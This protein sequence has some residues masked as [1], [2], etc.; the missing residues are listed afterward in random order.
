MKPR[1]W[2]SITL[3]IFILTAG[4]AISSCGRLF[5]P[6]PTITPLISSF[7]PSSSMNEIDCPFNVPNQAEYEVSCGQVEVPEDYAEIGGDQI[8][9]FIAILHATGENP[10]R[11]PIVLLPQSAGMSMV[12][13]IAYVGFQLGELLVER[14]L[15]YMEYRGLGNSGPRLDCPE[16]NEAYFQTWLEVLSP[17]QEAAIYEEGLQTCRDRL[18]NLEIDPASYTADEIAADLNAMRLS[19]GYEQF[20]LLAG[21]YGAEV[22]LTMLRDFPQSV[23]GVAVFEVG[24]PREYLRAEM[25]AISLQ[26]SLDLLFNSCQADEDC[27]LAYP[28]LEATL[29]GLVDQYNRQP[30]DVDLFVPGQTGLTPVKVTGSDFLLLIQSMLM[31]NQSI[32]NIPKLV[33]ELGQGQAIRMSDELQSYRMNLPDELVLGVEVSAACEGSHASYLQNT[34]DSQDVQAVIMEAVQSEARVFELVCPLWTGKQPGVPA[35]Q[36]LR[37]EVPL[38]I[39]QGEFTPHL[40]PNVVAGLVREM[41]NVQHIVIPNLSNDIFGGESC[42]GLLMFQWLDDPLADLDTSCVDST[43][44]ID[45]YMP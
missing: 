4:L 9:L 29:Y 17:D 5:A 44:P 28:N 14:D 11:D 15:V 36:P 25:T 43:E 22:A 34:P 7:N 24:I 30:V 31:T 6:E 32:S 39:L 45:F 37:S 38:L 13:V 2:R 20:N 26:G 12:D 35:G 18:L 42:A 27:R 3:L 19:L 23:R 8:E 16:Y 1:L 33:Y 21:G 40:S 41:D 10:R